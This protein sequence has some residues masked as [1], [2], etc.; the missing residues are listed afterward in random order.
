MN[1]KFVFYIFGRIAQTV[2][3]LMLLPALV[4]LIYSEYQTLI[5]FLVT[6]VGSLLLGTGIAV[7]CR[8]KNNVIYAKEGFAI[9]ALSWVGMSAI[10]ALPFVLSGDIPSYVDALFEMVSGFTTTGSSI[11]R[12][13]EALT[14]GALFWRSFSHW[15]GGMGVLVFVMAIVSSMTDRSIHIMRAEMPGHV[16]GK[17]VP[18]AGDTAKILYTIYSY[19][20]C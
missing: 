10:G 18:R 20:F 3:L 15:V 19:D 7:A 16:V 1:R 13:I 5:S 4:S 12:D 14:H 6:S 17:L 11:L 8:T 9:V 2:G